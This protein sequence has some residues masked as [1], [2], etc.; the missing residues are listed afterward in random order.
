MLLNGQCFILFQ[1]IISVDSKVILDKKVMVISKEVVWNS[2]DI[3]Y[4]ILGHKYHQN[5]PKY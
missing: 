2:W 5:H 3:L 4:T 1:S